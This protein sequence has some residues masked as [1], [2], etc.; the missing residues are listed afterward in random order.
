MRPIAS[1][2][3]AFSPISMFAVEGQ[4]E[5]YAGKGSGAALVGVMPPELKLLTSIETLLIPKMK[6]SGPIL[7]YLGGMVN[8]TALKLPECLFSGQLPETFVED[9]P[10]LQSLEINSNNFSGTIPDSFGSY[11]YLNSL[12]LSKNQFAG[13][14]PSVLGGLSE[15]RKSSIEYQQDLLLCGAS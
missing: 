14:I 11:Q 5:N 12:D 9:H 7:E 6:A 4:N 8:L 2:L 10:N 3:T 13:T 1:V 15:L